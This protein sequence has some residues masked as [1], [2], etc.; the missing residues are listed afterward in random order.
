MPEI[1][2]VAI[3]IAILAW[4][5][6]IGSLFSSSTLV[7]LLLIAMGT[8]V[9][10][11]FYLLRTPRNDRASYTAYNVSAMH[12]EPSSPFVTYDMQ[13]WLALTRIVPVLGPSVFRHS[14]FNVIKM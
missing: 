1:G 8:W 9:G 14:A 13:I 5:I 3:L 10:T 4:S 11:R 7:S 2:R 12:I 6:I